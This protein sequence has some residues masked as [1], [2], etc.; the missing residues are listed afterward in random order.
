MAT[1]NNVYYIISILWIHVVGEKITVLGYQ[2]AMEPPSI[3]MTVPVTYFE[4]SEA[5]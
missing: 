3:S 1:G 5:R 4:A 2:P